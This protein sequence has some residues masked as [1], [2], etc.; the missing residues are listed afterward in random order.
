MYPRISVSGADSPKVNAPASATAF[1]LGGAV[2]LCICMG[3]LALGHWQQSR[4]AYKSERLA[5]FASRAGDAPLALDQVNW[6]SDNLYRRVSVAGRFDPARQLLLDN[7]MRN[8][9]AGVLVYS[10]LLLAND[11]QIVV[12]RG[13]IARNPASR[14]E[15]PRIDTPLTDV[16]LLG[17]LAPAPATGLRLGAA[18]QPVDGRLLT[19][20]V[21]AEQIAAIGGNLGGP[22]LLRLD[23]DQAGALSVDPTPILGMPPDRHLAYA[24][25]WRALAAGL[26]GVYLVLLLRRLMMSNR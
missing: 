26:A 15:L 10:P 20:R 21:E 23:P 5:T 13:W 4:A 2:A 12:E 25:Q 16:Q 24:F 14:S 18:L 11:Q 8:G 9:R 22:L 3:F 19:T 7:Q 6:Q 17:S 1:I